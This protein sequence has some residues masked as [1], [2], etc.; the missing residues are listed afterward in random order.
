MCRACGKL[1]H[2]AKVCKSKG[3]KQV[4]GKPQKGKFKGSRSGPSSVPER[5]VHTLFLVRRKSSNLP[6]TICVIADGA[7]VE[8]EVDTGAAVSL[9]SQA[10]FNDAWPP[11]QRPR[12]RRTDVVLRTYTGEKLPVLGQ[13]Q[14]NVIFRDKTVSLPLVV[15]KGDGP[16]LMGGDWIGKLEVELQQLP[17]LYTRSTAASLSAMLA[18][19][20]DLFRDELGHVKG[21]KVKLHVDTS[22]KPQFFKPRPVPLTLKKRVGRQLQ[23]LEKAGVIEPVQFSDWAAPIVPIVK[24]DGSVRICR[25][26]KLTVN[27]VANV[28]SYPLPRIEDLLSSIGN[29]KVF[30]KLDLANAYQQ[31]E[32]EENSK[33]Y[34]TVSTHRGL[35]RYNRLPFGV[36]SIT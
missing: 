31:L 9:I 2:I 16:T 35:Y 25:D 21:L 14:V 33:E 34:V 10:K 13:I 27:R 6:L 26:Y 19:Y 22:C 17:V 24:R 23:R 7:N 30:S 15:V 32:L 11:L 29:S 28:D 12:L 8:F 20:D 18:K 1:G 5:E 3:D 36:V 4:A